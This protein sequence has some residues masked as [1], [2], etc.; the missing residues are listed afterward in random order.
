MNK[1]MKNL[2]LPPTWLRFLVI[3]L[4]LVG[5]FFRVF[6]LDQKVYWIDEAYTSLRISGY[7]EA[8]MIQQV[9]DGHVVS[10]EELQKYQRPHSETG[11]AGTLNSLAE[12][13][14]HPPLY[15][16]MARFWV[17]WFGHSVATPRSLSALISL[18][19]FPCL[20]WLCLE[21][22]KSPLVGWV[23]LMLMA[24]SPFHVLYAQ[25]ARPYSLWAV[26]TLLSSAALLRAIRLSTT[27]NWSIYA[28]TLTL[29]FYSFIFSGFV[30]IA[31][32]IYVVVSES[33]R[34]TKTVRAYLLASLASLIA[35]SP[36]LW[37]ITANI[38]QVHDTAA[39]TSKN[40]A[41]ERLVQRWLIRCSNV[42]FDLNQGHKFFSPST[43]IIVVL[44]FYSIYF[45]C[46]HTQKPVW[47]FI[48]TLIGVPALALILPDVILGGLR[49]TNARYFMP[50]YLG[51][52][53]SVAY[54]I[55]TQLVIAKTHLQQKLW[56][57]TLIALISG[58]ILSCGVSSQA[59]FWWNKSPDKH[60]YNPQIAY[61]VNQAEKPLL[62]SDNS[63]VIN[64]SFACRILSLSYLLAPK[65]QLQLVTEPNTPQIPDNF[66]D[67]FLF[68]PS[69]SLVQRIEKEQNYKTQLAFNR[70]NFWLWK[71]IRN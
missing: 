51:I 18:F 7:T 21:L 1:L 59:Q 9:F 22:F 36:W 26:A 53:L 70:D 61:L 66:S 12:S 43:L 67:V 29:G 49:S 64:D 45:L 50:C 40:L 2:A 3:S 34:W 8:Q 6:N 4:L 28:A 17:Q 31:H 52:Q 57:L 47:L 39:W 10:L 38:T 23:A 16:L 35:F 41:F 27:L 55:A 71:L 54:C 14:Q 11:I 48:L 25:E 62:I 32:G 63:T 20:Y 33:Y 44:V 15:Y 24:V 65:V 68:S 5:I 30:A 56:Q 13:P 19:V 58:G 60:K 42:F 46:R 69:E 37:V